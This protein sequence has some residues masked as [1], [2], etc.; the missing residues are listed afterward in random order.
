MLVEEAG[1]GP[2]AAGGGGLDFRVLDGGGSRMEAGVQV[3]EASRKRGEMGGVGWVWV[4]GLRSGPEFSRVYVA[5]SVFSDGRLSPFGVGKEEVP[6]ALVAF[7]TSQRAG[8]KN[9]F[10]ILG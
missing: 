2:G 8:A 4:L 5:G 1:E 6:G 3:F 9:I 10:S 7:Q